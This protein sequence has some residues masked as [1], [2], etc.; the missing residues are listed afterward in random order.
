[1]DKLLPYLEKAKVLLDHIEKAVLL[2]AL[3][4]LGYFAIVKML[5]KNSLVEE[6]TKAA[7]TTRGEIRIGGE[8]LPRADVSLFHKSLNT[9]TNTNKT[10]RIELL[11]GISNHFLFSPEVWMTNQSLGLFRADDGE[12]KRG[13][14]AVSV[15]DPPYSLTMRIWAEVRLN[16]SG[17]VV[18]HYITV[19][20]EYLRYQT[21]NQ[22]IFTNL[23]LHPFMPTT[24]AILLGTNRAGG[25]VPRSFLLPIRGDNEPYVNWVN[26]TNV[27]RAGFTNDL[28]VDQLE[29][30]WDV[31]PDQF[32]NRI[33]KHANPKALKMLERKFSLA[34][35]DDPPLVATQYDPYSH[36]ERLVAH[37]YEHVVVP[38]TGRHYFKMKLYL[39]PATNIVHFGAENGMYPPLQASVLRPEDK[40]GRCVNFVPGFAIRR[41]EFI[42]LEYG[43]D[44]NQY[45]V[46]EACR[47]GR[48]LFVDGQVFVVERVTPTHVVLGKDP[49]FTAANDPARDRKYPLPIPGAIPAAG[50][51]PGG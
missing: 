5:E 23:V 18:N 50:G 28:H 11:K 46:F 7:P 36:P 43:K 32:E 30:T 6:I 44:T 27:V 25:I 17:R 22:E 29:R 49:E 33:L 1:M 51:R 31:F 24:N 26:W 4:T 3:G 37:F 12:R 40:E 14:E 42:D 39:H 8:M 9:A 35:H 47:P 38:G 34:G 10:P 21:T 2:A 13:I 48:K 15:K 45:I 41:G 20:D 19:R 16:T